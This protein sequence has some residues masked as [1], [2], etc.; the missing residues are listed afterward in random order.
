MASPFRQLFP[1]N[2]E[3]APHRVVPD[4]RDPRLFAFGSAA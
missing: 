4:L 2:H 3:A 1:W